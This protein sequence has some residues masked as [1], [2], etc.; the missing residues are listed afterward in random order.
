MISWG[1]WLKITVI[2]NNKISKFWNKIWRKRFSFFFH[3][4]FLL[5]LFEIHKGS[6]ASALGPP[7]APTHVGI[8]MNVPNTEGRS[9]NLTPNNAQ[10]DRLMSLPLSFCLGSSQAHGT[11]RISCRLWVPPSPACRAAP[12]KPP[13]AGLCFFAQKFSC[14]YSQFHQSWQI[15]TIIG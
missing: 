4:S 7:R 12:Q 3:F 11:L 2:V 10:A 9:L 15:Y 14:W 6:C 8:T 1:L 5:L 13:P